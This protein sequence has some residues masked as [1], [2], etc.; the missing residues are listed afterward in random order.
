MQ[1]G[2]RPRSLGRGIIVENVPSPAE[3]KSHLLRFGVPPAVLGLTGTGSQ[4]ARH[5]KAQDPH[6]QNCTRGAK[7]NSFPN[8]PGP[9]LSDRSASAQKQ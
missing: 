9:E 4:R 7:E 6:H 1:S 3:K 5:T 8:F 2:Q